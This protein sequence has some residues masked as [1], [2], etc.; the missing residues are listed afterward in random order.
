MRGNCL[1]SSVNYIYIYMN[2]QNYWV[3]KL[4]K[5]KTALI[6]RTFSGVIS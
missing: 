4:E 3:L 1:T 5:H 2:F 6:K